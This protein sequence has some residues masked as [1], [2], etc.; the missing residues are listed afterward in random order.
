M[1]N[2]AYVY[3]GLLRQHGIL[4]IPTAFNVAYVRMSRDSTISCTS[5]CS[6]LNEI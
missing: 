4:I 3:V 1:S 2:G 5:Y 6:L